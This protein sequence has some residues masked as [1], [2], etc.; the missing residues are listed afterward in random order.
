MVVYL[1]ACAIEDTE[2]NIVR[3]QWRHKTDLLLLYNNNKSVDS[4][5]E[6]Q[7]SGR[8]LG[9][10]LYFE[11]QWATELYKNICSTV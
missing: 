1:I 4:R 10:F 3:H 6:Y 7:L 2:E 5:Q 11:Y 8:K 9:I